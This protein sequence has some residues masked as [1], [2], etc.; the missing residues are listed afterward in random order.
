MKLSRHTND[1]SIVSKLRDG[2]SRKALATYYGVSIGRIGEIARAAAVSGGTAI[3]AISEPRRQLEAAGLNRSACLIIA[4]AAVT[5][6][7]AVEIASIAK[8][9]GWDRGWSSQRQPPGSPPRL[10]TFALA[11]HERRQHH[12]LRSCPTPCP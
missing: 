5:G 3:R 7:S 2:T 1:K 4:L 10:A 9:H 6:R 12:A 8:R 11:G